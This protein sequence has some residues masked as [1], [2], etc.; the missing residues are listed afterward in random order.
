[1]NRETLVQADQSEIAAEVLIAPS[2]EIDL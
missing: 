1:M 2:D